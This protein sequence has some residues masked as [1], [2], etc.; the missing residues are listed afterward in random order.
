MT[1][2]QL[3]QLF[4][5]AAPKRPGLIQALILPPGMLAEETVDSVVI[6]ALES[7]LVACNAKTGAARI[8]FFPRDRVPTGWARIGV[9]HRPTTPE[10]TPCAA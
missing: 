3:T 4:A 10:P 9:T 2:E 7:G 6:A 1:P 5:A 8:A